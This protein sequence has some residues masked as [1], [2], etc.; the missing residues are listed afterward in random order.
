MTVILLCS[1]PSSHDNLVDTMMYGRDS[2]SLEDVKLSLLSREMKRKITSRGKDSIGANALI[3]R[4]R[5][6]KRGF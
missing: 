6:D 5:I 4:G 2:L 1:L 3:T